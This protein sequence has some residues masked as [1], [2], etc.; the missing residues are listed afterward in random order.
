MP[1]PRES[2]W[3]ERLQYTP[4][5]AGRGEIFLLGRDRQQTCL[6]KVCPGERPPA[7]GAE[8][9]EAVRRLNNIREVEKELDSFSKHSLQWI[10]NLQTNSQNLPQWCTQKEGG[11]E[12]RRMEA[13]NSRDLQEEEI[14]PKPE[15]PL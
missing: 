9:Q 11:Q 14:S 7:E 10:Q 6:Q 4:V 1:L 12:C 15:V 8:L 5:I 3:W 2:C 13:C